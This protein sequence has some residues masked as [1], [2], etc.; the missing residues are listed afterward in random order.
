MKKMSAA[1]VL[2]LCL[3][4]ILG[5]TVVYAHIA[6]CPDDP[7]LNIGR[8]K[9]H[10]TTWVPPDKV[11]LVNGPVHVKVYVPRN[12][13]AEVIEYGTGYGKGEKVVIISN[14]K[15]VEPGETIKF[16]VEVKVSA[17]E[18]FTV[19]VTIGPSMGE[20]IFLCSGQ[21]NKWVKCEA[22]LW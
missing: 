19:D 17:K 6:W 18:T 9:V 22:E 11:N 16:D 12:V 13:A 21:S 7:I 14:K 8:T 2:T 10:V 20:E 1:T 5:S 4:L 3:V 15:P